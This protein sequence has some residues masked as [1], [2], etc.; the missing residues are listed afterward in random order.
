MQI[1]YIYISGYQAVQNSRIV[2][3]KFVEWRGQGSCIDSN[4][5]AGGIVE[6]S[7]NSSCFRSNIT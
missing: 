6:C 5:I 4:I 3:K 1:I 2:S 7:G